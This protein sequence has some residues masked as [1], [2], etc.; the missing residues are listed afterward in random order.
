MKPFLIIYF[1]GVGN[2]KA[3]AEQIK[4]LAFKIP[5]EIYS[6][7]NLPDDFS[8][9]NYSAVIIGTPTY[10]SE[11]AKPL[12]K[13][14]EAVNPSRKIPAFVFTTCGLYSENCLRVLAKECLKH[15]IIPIHSA[16]YRCCATDGILLTPFMDCWF[17][18]EKDLQMKIKMVR[19]KFLYG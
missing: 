8:F 17:Q 12:M 6:V 4:G 14:I 18:N 7:E 3:V 9:D 16:S 19:Q 2:T 10:H 1:S 5:T 13:F 15:R 11:P